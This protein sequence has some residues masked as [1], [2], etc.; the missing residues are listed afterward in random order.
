MV[1]DF[2]L[3]LANLPR[4]LS[5]TGKETEGRL[6]RDEC[7]TGKAARPSPSKDWQQIV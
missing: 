5:Q 7:P 3:E 1:G 4:E 6:D 2:R